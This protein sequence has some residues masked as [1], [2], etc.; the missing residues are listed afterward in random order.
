MVG[1]SG[2]VCW[3]VVMCFFLRALECFFVVICVISFDAFSFAVK[4]NFYF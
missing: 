1:C 3:V 2:G 4:I